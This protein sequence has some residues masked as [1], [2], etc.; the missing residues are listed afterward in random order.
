MDHDE[1]VDVR[2]KLYSSI[3]DID[4]LCH[5]ID[6]NP[7]GLKTFTL[8]KYSSIST[9]QIKIFRSSR[10]K[11]LNSSS[12]LKINFNENDP[13]SLLTRFRSLSTYHLPSTTRRHSTKHTPQSTSIETETNSNNNTSCSVEE[14]A[15]YLDDLLYLP[16]SLSGAAELMYT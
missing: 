7:F 10:L 15:A 3:S 6:E 5:L 4:Q 13:S 8:S 11:R 16:K 12:N 1:K 2:K 9:Y 14:L